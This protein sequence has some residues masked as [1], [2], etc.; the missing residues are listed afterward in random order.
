MWVWVKAPCQR[1]G[2]RGVSRVG[3]CH[4]LLWEAEHKRDRRRATVWRMPAG[5]FSFRS[6]PW[7]LRSASRSVAH[8]ASRPRKARTS[9]LE[10][11]KAWSW[12]RHLPRRRL[13][14]R[15]LPRRRRA[16]RHHHRPRRRRHHRRRRRRRSRR[17]RHRPRRRP[18]SRPHT[19]RSRRASRPSRRT[20]QDAPLRRLLRRRLLRLRA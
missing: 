20:A 9:S 13:P 2:V 3:R 5:R 8:R 14:R 18:R 17:P 15:H 10:R 6:L 19:L 1:V 7:P 12:Q 11:T 4:P 16:H